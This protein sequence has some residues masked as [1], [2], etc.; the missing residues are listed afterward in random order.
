MSMNKDTTRNAFT[1]LEL[2]AAIVVM[3]VISVVVLPVLSSASESYS[4]TRDIRSRTEHLA[5]ALDRVT[6]MIRQA[7]IGTGGTGVGIQSAGTTSLIFTDGTGFELNSGKLEMIVPGEPNA[8]LCEQVD[9]ME[10]L[11]LQA[12]GVSSALAAPQQAH[13]IVV[14]LTSGQLEMSVVAHPR[15]WIGQGGA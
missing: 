1:L 7:P 5:F 2:L 12:D 10:V 13:R 4:T 14:T 11:Y 8:L 6:R 3:A 15:V 9:A